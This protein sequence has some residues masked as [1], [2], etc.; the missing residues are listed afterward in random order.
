MKELHMADSDGSLEAQLIDLY[1]G[2]RILL[3]ELGT[4]EPTQIV[5]MVRGLEEQLVAIYGE[6]ADTES[7]L[8]VFGPK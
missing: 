8:P 6:R 3:T 5:A 2:Q 7:E 1:R 4:C